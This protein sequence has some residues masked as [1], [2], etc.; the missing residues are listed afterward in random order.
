MIAQNQGL[1]QQ[2]LTVEK[3]VSSGN[4]DTLL[5]QL[6]ADWFSILTLLRG[7]CRIEGQ[8]SHGRRSIAFVPGDIC[9]IAPNNLI[10]L[11]PTPP[12]RRPFEVACIRLPAEVLRS[13]M[14]TR[15]DIATQDLS[16]LQTL[17]F[18]DPHIASMAPALLGARNAGADDHYATSAAHYLAAYLLHPQRSTPSRSG[19]LSPEQQRAVTAYMHEHLASAITLD[20]LAKEAVLSRYHFIRRF[21]ATTGKT[22]LQ[23]LTELRIDTARQHLAV[24]SEPISQV[25]RRCGFPSPE[26]FARVFRKHVGCSPSQYRRR[27]THSGLRT[28]TERSES[29][30]GSD[31][32]RHP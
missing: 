19:C 18:F 32:A 23:Y 28:E 7:S 14:D 27:A 1:T 15:P 29:P 31:S 21:A 24:G 6:P 8:D 11:S 13:E 4:S 22:P 10:R 12:S 9:R 2:A 30:T 17:R 5:Y 20:H 3:Q 16:A 26:N 25:G